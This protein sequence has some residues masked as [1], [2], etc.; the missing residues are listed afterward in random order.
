M[1]NLAIGAHIPAAHKEIMAKNI[2]YYMNKFGKTRGEICESLG[3][4]YTTFTDWVNGNSYPRIDKIEIMANYFGISKSDLMEEHKPKPD[5]KKIFAKKLNYYMELNGKTQT[6]LINELN[7]NKSAISTWCNGARMPRMDKV[8]MLAD[9]FG[10]NKSDLLEE[11][12]EEDEYYTNKETAQIAQQIFE[13]K[14]LKLLFD[15]A[16]DADPE[17][18]KTV[19]TMLVALKKKKRCT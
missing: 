19:L 1:L 17:D 4:K 11:K 6:D 13:N 7:L 5:H 9:Y 8:Q 2:K 15:A 3:I 14:E 12:R 16:Q 10:V 18:L